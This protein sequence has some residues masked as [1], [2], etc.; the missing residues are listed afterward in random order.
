MMNKVVI[1]HSD[2]AADAAYALEPLPSSPSDVNPSCAASAL[3][4]PML[5]AGWRRSLA[6]VAVVQHQPR[7]RAA[8]ALVAC[9]HGQQQPDAP[10]AQFT[11]AHGV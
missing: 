11:C 8:N 7:S 2:V 1:L 10:P 5:L 3:K 9:I 4:T 6:R